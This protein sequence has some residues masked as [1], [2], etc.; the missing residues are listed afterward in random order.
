MET[1]DEDKLHI[2]DLV[3][4]AGGEWYGFLF[5]NPSQQLPPTLTWCFN[6]PFE[7]VSRKDEDTPLSLAVGWLSIPAG[8][9][10]RLAG[11][12][13]T[14]ASFGKPAEASFYYYLHHR[15]NTTTLDLV[16]QRGRSLRAVATVSGDIDHLGIDP[17]HADAWLTFTGILVSLHDVTS[18]D[19]ALARLNQFTDTDGLALDTGGSEA[20][21]RFTT[22]PD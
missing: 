21:L 13:M 14:N 3:A 18:P 19:V 1:D 5:D 15:F 4:A 9:W 16:E 17:V 11:H 12:H 6:F 22:R 2:E 20:A 10:R 8:S 7:D